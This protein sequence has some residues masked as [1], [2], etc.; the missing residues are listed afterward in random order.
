M[1]IFILDNYDSFTYNLV[2]IIE[3]FATK[4]IVKRNNECNISEIK[5]FDKIILSP[6][7]GLPS[8]VPIIH[9][10]INKYKESKSILGV[11]LGHQ[12]IAEYFGGNIINM[13]EVNHGR[14]F[15]T[16]IIKN[17]Y[18]FKNVPKTFY[19]GRYHSWVVNKKDFP[20]SLEITSI[21]SK[22]QIMS[23]RHK[24]YDIRGVQ[25]HPESIMTKYGKKILQNW[26]DFNTK[27]EV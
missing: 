8:E 15:E 18:I 4:I 1:K 22:N 19:S 6:G 10:I 3:Q 17:D 14:E 23:L 9:E 25:F 20:N 24:T 21:D 2:H 27:Y 12:S 7:P 16:K 13:P 11:C 5:D 26:V